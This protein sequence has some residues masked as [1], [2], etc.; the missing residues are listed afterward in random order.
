MTELA[1][2]MTVNGERRRVLVEPR[3]IRDRGRRVI[4]IGYVP[5]GELGAA[6]RAG[7]EGEV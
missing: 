6:G 4:G 7:G 3:R 5:T 2:T 1:V